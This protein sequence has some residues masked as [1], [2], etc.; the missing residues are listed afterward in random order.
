METAVQRL[1][2]CLRTVPLLVATE[3]E[4][5]LAP[6]VTV[7]ALA[8]VHLA[9]AVPVVQDAHRVHLALES[10]LMTV[11]EVAVLGATVVPDANRSAN[12]AV[13]MAVITAALL[14]LGG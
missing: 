1:A 11:T 10:V 8:D 3:A 6:A 5:A 14:R 2:M 4:A 7:V 13:D 12:R 9:L